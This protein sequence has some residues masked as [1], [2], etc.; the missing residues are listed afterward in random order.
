MYI[1][2]SG[3]DGSGKSTIGKILEEELENHFEKIT[4]CDGIKP[5]NYSDLLR[6]TAK[7]LNANYFDYFQDLSLIAFS[8][9]LVNTY[10][11]KLKNL[12]ETQDVLITHRNKLC[13]LTYSM[14]RDKNNKAINVIKHIIKDIPNPDFYFHLDV[15]AK[16][17]MRRIEARNLMTGAK[18]SINEEIELLEK[19]NEIYNEN[20]KACNVPV[21]RFDTENLSRT[22]I[23][24]LM[25][26]VISSY[27]VN[28]NE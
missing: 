5:C 20:I 7:N 24:N 14:L 19:L 4:F 9:D 1:A 6:K 25:L 18:K 26:E 28:E 8:L 11:S 17:A 3:I 16:E 10:E 12:Y 15:S 23:I 2:L 22:E 21:Y 27:K 13:C